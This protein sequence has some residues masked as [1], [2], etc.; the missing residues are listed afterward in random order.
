MH[1][2]HYGLTPHHSP[3]QPFESFDVKDFRHEVTEVVLGVH[4]FEPADL[5]ISQSLYPLLSYVDVLQL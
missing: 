3:A 4:L 1:A 2:L 5:M